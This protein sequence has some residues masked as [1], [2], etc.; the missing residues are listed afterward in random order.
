MGNEMQT[1]H[2]FASIG[3]GLYADLILGH[4]P[5][6]AV[7]LDPVRCSILRAR[8]DE[9]W[10]PELDVWEGD[11]RQWN[12]SEWKGR[13]DCLHAGFPCQDISVAGSGK[14]LHGEKSGLFFEVIR[15]VRAIRP[16][17]V[18]LENSPNITGLGL[19]T[20][21]AALASCGYMGAWCCLAAEHVGAPHKRDRWWCLAADHT[22]AR[23]L[24]RGRTEPAH[25]E[26]RAITQ[27]AAD[28]GGLRQ[29]QP[30]RGKPDKCR[31]VSNGIEKV[32][33]ING[34]RWKEPWRSS[35]AKETLESNKCVGWWS[36]EPDVVRMVHGIPLGGHRV[37][38]LGDSQV[39]LQAA[40][41]WMILEEVLRESNV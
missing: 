18:F 23:W 22:G 33:D 15:A 29:L 35:T 39:P 30:Q 6:L 31:R 37:A 14:G 38:G 12:P 41:A 24:K 16:G 17:L 13:L 1:G 27:A 28:V 25:K 7:E 3:G 5:R 10:W 2:L 32:T 19:D 40:T 9:G 8:R 11:I 4:T 21:T 26:Y 20:I 36:T 34:K